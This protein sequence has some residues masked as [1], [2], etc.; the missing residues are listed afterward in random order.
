VDISPDRRQGEEVDGA[1]IFAIVAAGFGALALRRARPRARLQLESPFDGDAD[2]AMHV[3]GHEARQRDQLLTATHVLYGL[4]QDEQI[5]EAIRKTGGDVDALEDR[6]LA[7]LDREVTQEDADATR[8]ALATAVNVADGAGNPRRCGVVD[9]WAYLTR[10]DQAL[11]EAAKVD[12][13]AVLFVLFHGAPAPVVD[14]IGGDVHVVL[15]NDDYTTRD[16]V[17]SVLQE[18]FALDEAVAETRMMVTHTEGR[19]VIGRYTAADARAKI[20]EVRER[21]HAGGYPLWIG[22]EPI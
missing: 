10:G 9:L 2:V 21:A 20:R 11:L 3:A 18:V 14:V 13:T 17:C 7:A 5:A 15:R 4:V 22:I 12:R 1:T 19:G 8:R 6:I 16:F